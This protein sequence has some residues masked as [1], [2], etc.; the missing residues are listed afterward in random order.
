MWLPIISVIVSVS[1]IATVVDYPFADDPFS[2]VPAYSSTNANRSSVVRLVVLPGSA[3]AASGFVM[4]SV[5]VILS[6]ESGGCGCE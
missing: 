3:I 4:F 2:N 5:S 6:P 1:I